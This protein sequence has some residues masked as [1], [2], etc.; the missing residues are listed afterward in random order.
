MTKTA[1]KNQKRKDKQQEGTSKPASS[2]VNAAI[3]GMQRL[4][5]S[6]PEAAAAPAAV[7]ATSAAVIDDEASL[8][9]Q[10]R[11]LK[12]KVSTAYSTAVPVPTIIAVLVLI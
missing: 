2:G 7:E 5:V 10:I 3:A 11:G 8:E 12:K 6:K 4:G 1:K 9:K